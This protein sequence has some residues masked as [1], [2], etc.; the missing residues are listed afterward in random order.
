MRA[1][2]I[3]QPWA[4]AIAFADKRVENRT[5]PTSYRGPILIHAGKSLDRRS[6]PMVASAL[7]GLQLERGAVLAVARIV[8]CHDSTD[9]K[10]PCTPWS[11]TGLFHHVLDEV[12]ALPLPISWP[13]AQGLWIPSPGLMDLVREQLSAETAAHL[14]R[15]EADS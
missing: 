8:G 6:G 14:L 5:W 2:T 3:R 9:E 13:G 7:R 4:A 11:A 12:T 15:E 1:L 10:T